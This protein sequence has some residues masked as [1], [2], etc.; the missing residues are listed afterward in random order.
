MKLKTAERHKKNGR[1][2]NTTYNTLYV[3]IPGPVPETRYT[4]TC[5]AVQVYIQVQ[6][7]LNQN[8]LAKKI[9]VRVYL[10]NN[11]ESK[12]V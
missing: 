10:E 12:P 1:H 5:T 6:L 9:A 8:K 4:C 2:A 3:Y 7:S 11:L